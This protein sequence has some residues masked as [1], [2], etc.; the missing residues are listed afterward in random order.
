MNTTKFEVGDAIRVKHRDDV[1]YGI[2][3][4]LINELAELGTLY[5]ARGNGDSYFITDGIDDDDVLWK[6][7][8]FHGS[9]LERVEIDDNSEEFDGSEII[10]RLMSLIS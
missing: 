8:Y 5:I 10:D 9:M 1:Y 6:H 2:P 7:L 3:T 4:S